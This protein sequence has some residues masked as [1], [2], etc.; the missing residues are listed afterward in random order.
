MGSKGKYQEGRRC[1]VNL[2]SIH[3]SAC[4]AIGCEILEKLIDKRK[5][6]KLSNV[7]SRLEHSRNMK[8]GEIDSTWFVFFMMCIQEEVGSSTSPPVNFRELK[9]CGIS[10][11]DKL[12]IDVDTLSPMS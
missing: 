8:V 3:A 12:C 7:S 11:F 4:H 10:L 1:L 9:E 6:F 5:K 2:Y